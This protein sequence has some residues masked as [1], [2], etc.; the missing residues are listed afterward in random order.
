MSCPWTTQEPRIP[1]LC[2]A[3]EA[4][5][6]VPLRPK[7]R[8]R[9][10]LSAPRERPPPCRGDMAGSSNTVEYL[11]EYPLAAPDRDPWC[12]TDGTGFVWGA[13]VLVA[14]RGLKSVTPSSMYRP[15]VRAGWRERSPARGGPTLR[16]A[17]AC[18]A[19]PAHAGASSNGM[20]ACGRFENVRERSS[21]RGRQDGTVSPDGEPDAAGPRR[22][23]QST[24]GTIARRRCGYSG[25]VRRYQRRCARARGTRLAAVQKAKRAAA[26]DP[27]RTA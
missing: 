18:G 24:N 25:N 13:G 11:V 16:P 9:T 8:S 5:K 19:R 2:N 3:R 6:S 20:M 12:G 21:Q 22:P 26:G 7:G 17:P 14:C 1:Y 10:T 4:S 15:D 27:V 23:I